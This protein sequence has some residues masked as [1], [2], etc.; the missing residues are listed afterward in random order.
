MAAI[1]WARLVFPVILVALVT[2]YAWT[3]CRTEEKK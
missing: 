1:L 2:V 3:A